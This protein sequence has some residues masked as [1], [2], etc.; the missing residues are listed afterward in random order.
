MKDINK[1]VEELN[2]IQAKKK[3]KR[4]LIGGA[5]GLGV[6]VLIAG[7][8]AGS[9]LSS[10]T[11][12]SST[13]S[14]T[15]INSDLPSTLPN[16][17][18]D[19]IDLTGDNTTGYLYGVSNPFSTSISNS[20]TPILNFNITNTKFSSVLNNTD[21][22]TQ[23]GWYLNGKLQTDSELN[24]INSNYNQLGSQTLLLS[25]NTASVNGNWNVMILITNKTTH[26][27]IILKSNSVDVDFSNDFSSL[28]NNKNTITSSTGSVTQGNGSTIIFNNAFDWKNAPSNANSI[29]ANESNVPTISY[30]WYS[31]TN[32][33]SSQDLTNAMNNKTFSIN[34][35]ATTLSS[36][37]N[38]LQISDAS[39]KANT[40]FFC[41]VKVVYQGNLIYTSTSNIIQIQYNPI[42]AN[43]LNPTKNQLPQITQSKSV[44]DYSS[45]ISNNENLSQSIVVSN[46]LDYSIKASLTSSNSTITNNLKDIS[47]QVNSSNQ[48]V[49]FNI[50]N[51]FTNLT[52]TEIENLNNTTFTITLDFYYQNTLISSA[53]L[54]QTYTLNYIPLM[55]SVT[56]STGET[57]S[58][59]NYNTTSNSIENGLTLNSVLPD[60]ANFS[61]ASIQSMQWEYQIN[62][63]STIATNYTN[64]FLSASDLINIIK[65]SNNAKTIN[66]FCNY[67]ITDD[68]STSTITSNVFV[69]NINYISSA[70]ANV[71]LSLASN[72]SP[73]GVFVSNQTLMNSLNGFYTTNADGSI[74]STGSAILIDVNGYS[75]LSS[76]SAS[77]FKVIGE[78]STLDNFI[79]GIL[80]YK[81]GVVSINVNSSNWNSLVATMTNNSGS[82]AISLD[83]STSNGVVSYTS[84][85]ITI[86]NLTNSVSL[87]NIESSTSQTLSSH[88]GNTINIGTISQTYAKVLTSDSLN[89]LQTAF[90]SEVKS[91]YLAPKSI[92]S[93]TYAIS[94]NNISIPAFS[95]TGTYYYQVI[96][97]NEVIINGWTYQV[98]SAPSFNQYGTITITSS[99]NNRK[100]PSQASLPKIIGFSSDLYYAP[101]INNSMTGSFTISNPYNYTF[102]AS[103]IELVYS[104]GNGEVVIPS[105]D[106]TFNNEST[107][108]DNYCEINYT[109]NFSSKFIAETGLNSSSIGGG[110]IGIQITFDDADYTGTIQPS[111]KDASFLMIQQIN[112]P[113]NTSSG[114]LTNGVAKLSATINGGYNSNTGGLTANSIISAISNFSAISSFDLSSVSSVISGISSSFVGWEL[115]DNSTSTMLSFANEPT[116]TL[117]ENDISDLMS[118]LSTFKTDKVSLIPVYE[119]TYNNNS[120]KFYGNAIA[121]SFN[122]TFSALSQTNST[123]G[124]GSTNAIYN[125]NNSNQDYTLQWI[126]NGGNTPS[127]F[128]TN[129]VNSSSAS[130]SVASVF[131]FKINNNSVN[132]TSNSSLYATLLQG[133]SVEAN[134][135]ISLT[136]TNAMYQSILSTLSNI[137]NTSNLNIQLIFN[138]AYVSSL[139][140][141]SS[142]LSVTPTITQDS[143]GTAI[144]YN[145]Q[146]YQVVSANNVFGI[147]NQNASVTIE[148]IL[149]SAFSSIISQSYSVSYSTSSSSGYSV[150]TSTNIT[151]GNWFNFALNNSTGTWYY[152]ITINT[153][154]SYDG[155]TYSITQNSKPA[156]YIAL[157]SSDYGLNNVVWTNTNNTLGVF[158]NQFGQNNSNSN[159]VSSVSVTWNNPFYISL[160]P[161]I[162]FTNSSSATSPLSSS[163]LEILASCFSDANSTNWTYS[164]GIYSYT[165]SALNSSYSGSLSFSLQLNSTLTTTQSALINEI[166]SFSSDLNNIFEMT[167]KLSNSA[168]QTNTFI[169]SNLV[170]TTTSTPSES[171]SATVSWSMINDSYVYGSF[172]SD[173]P[174]MTPTIW[175][176]NGNS[177]TIDNLISA[178]SSISFGSEIDTFINNSNIVYSITYDNE[179]YDSFLGYG[180]NITIGD[181]INQNFTLIQQNFNS[182]SG[183]KFLKSQTFNYSINLY[184]N[185][186]S[187]Q[188]TTGYSNSLSITSNYSNSGVANILNGITGDFYDETNNTFYWLNGL[189]T[190]ITL[191]KSV[192]T[193]TAFSWNGTSLTIGANEDVYE[194]SNGGWVLNFGNWGFS[195]VNGSNTFTI[196]TSSG[197]ESYIIQIQSYTWSNIVNLTTPTITDEN[198]ANYSFSL[199]FSNVTNFFATQLSTYLLQNVNPNAWFTGAN[200]NQ[201]FY[202][203]NEPN[204]SGTENWLYSFFMITSYNSY[205]NLISSDSQSSQ[206]EINPLYA[207]SSD[208]SNNPTITYD[209]STMTFNISNI[210]WYQLYALY[211]SNQ[212]SPVITSSYY[213]SSTDNNITSSFINWIDNIY[214]NAFAPSTTTQN[215]YIYP[216]VNNISTSTSI[217]QPY[218]QISYNTSSSNSLSNTLTILPSITNIKSILTNNSIPLFLGSQFGVN[219]SI[220]QDNEAFLKQENIVINDYYSSSQNASGIVSPNWISASISAKLLQSQSLYITKIS[221]NGINV[222]LQDAL[223]FNDNYTLSKKYGILISSDSSN[224]FNS[225][226]YIYIP[227]NVIEGLNNDKTGNDVSMNLSMTFAIY[228]TSS[229]QLVSTS[230]SSTSTNVTILNSYGNN[231]VSFSLPS[232]IK[233]FSQIT[234]PTSPS[235][236]I[237]DNDWYLIFNVNSYIGGNQSGY[238]YITIPF[239]I[240]FDNL[241][242]WNNYKSQIFSS[243]Y[244]ASSNVYLVQ[245][246]NG[247]FNYIQQVSYT[248]PSQQTLYTTYVSST[249]MTNSSSTITTSFDGG[250]I[251]QVSAYPLVEQEEYNTSNIA[252]S[253]QEIIN[254][255][256]NGSY[257]NYGDFSNDSSY[258][259][260]TSTNAVFWWNLVMNYTSLTQNIAFATIMSISNYSNYLLY[261][262]N[263]SSSEYSNSSINFISSSPAMW[264]YQT[265]SNATHNSAFGSDSPL[266]SVSGTG[267]YSPSAIAISSDVAK[268]TI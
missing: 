206:Y 5:I 39:I 153:T 256:Y 250:L 72:Q 70:I 31:T 52:K 66:L 205:S 68:S 239:F 48:Q 268:N 9:L 120:Y 38:S 140:L 201:P 228:T 174:T 200:E 99:G 246:A 104:Y 122:F 43:P 19:G 58:T 50:S 3:N 158:N 110:I 186:V 1:Q 36:S 150:G 151:D 257:N 56:S 197:S 168:S 88:L 159:Y 91:I 112:N 85:S 6:G 95:T 108:F 116:W 211:N 2:N 229:M 28:F 238:S 199:S 155:V 258:T 217:L 17:L 18:S 81:N 213:N 71:S 4:L 192:G 245:I 254:N 173:T 7:G 42:N 181:T 172:S 131:Q 209:S 15:T 148:N 251:Y 115:S 156:Q 223:Y 61:N 161:T 107:N 212:D 16:T 57:S 14:T 135:V 111:T 78:N 180:S 144:L 182:I 53:T 80:T 32:Y 60:I 195:L 64:S 25:N 185:N 236:Y 87:G 123:I 86:F 130:S 97:V 118:I 231:P 12:T 55:V 121:L 210:N 23:I 62:N 265:P 196:T 41:I 234:A 208:S 8:V 119:I 83:S 59:I 163:Q 65:D 162:S 253:S 260:T 169:M 177:K 243:L 222:D 170:V 218:S 105:S 147:T 75:K 29:L 27:R 142:S 188:T 226:P 242:D 191:P 149:P 63:G 145:L 152:V 215:D 11:T 187:N 21:Y 46:P 137:S 100:N 84:P 190:T 241:S 248:P 40:L 22:S 26:Q 54:S 74:N 138:N 224:S 160:N 171:V 255:L 47:F 233:Y 266:I 261:I 133:L 117:T 175:F 96:V 77:D 214:L 89:D 157:A 79:Q 227:Q 44:I 67:V 49:S 109:L 45:N 113:T 154:F 216:V 136:I 114:V 221:I 35:D 126:Y 92:M 178:K 73:N 33:A 76:I 176:K 230:T 124:Y 128:Y 82:F 203:S 129:Y 24:T 183:S 240:S 127:Y 139:T 204:S 219:N 207:Y 225:S 165:G 252:L 267:G 262:G 232:S 69:L 247:M 102:S 259:F 237:G 164:D 51:L 141:P 143:F 244:Y 193:I 189:S 202:F 235:L 167:F 98:F 184:L 125:S 20:K 10:H 30:T 103:G 37:T 101:S 134:G 146:S 13:S 93:S 264:F 194:N 263:S 94:N 166:E 179:T 34:T 106:I 249:S 220:E 90:K 132:N 198:V